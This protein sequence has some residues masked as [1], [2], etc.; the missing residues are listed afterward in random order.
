MQ[1]EHDNPPLPEHMSS[2]LRFD[3]TGNVTAML[4]MNRDFMRTLMD[5]WFDSAFIVMTEDDEQGTVVLPSYYLAN[6]KPLPDRL[7]SSL[8]KWML[9]AMEWDASDDE[10]DF[11]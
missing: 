2:V 6:G 1:F 8:S 11:D 5:W 10:F 9:I 7:A 3:S 4:E